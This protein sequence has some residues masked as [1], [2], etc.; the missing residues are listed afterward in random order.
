MKKETLVFQFIVL[1]IGSKSQ[2]E[3]NVYGTAFRQQLFESSLLHL[4][5][6]PYSKKSRSAKVT[7]GI[8]NLIL[9]NYLI[10]HYKDITINNATEVN[11]QKTFCFNE[12]KYIC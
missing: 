4:P 2:Q 5:G 10:D 7:D 3:I 11:L 9:R 12:Q 6:H 8:I 1:F